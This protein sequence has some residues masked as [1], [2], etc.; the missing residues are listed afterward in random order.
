MKIIS[1]ITLLVIPLAISLYFMVPKAYYK[2]TPTQ[3]QVR[4]AILTPTTHPALQEIEQGFK[5]T[6]Q[7]LSSKPYTFTTFNANGNK[8]LLRAQAEEIILGN[9]QLIFT[10]GAGC[11]QTIAELLRKKG[12]HTPHLFGAIDSHAFAAS[13]RDMN[14]SSTGVYVVVD[15]KPT[16]DILHELKPTTKNILLVYDPTHGTGLEKYKKELADYVKKFGMTLHSSEIYQTN[17]IQ[18]KVAALLP[19]MDAVLVLIDNSVV[20]GIDALVTLCNRYGV[21]LVASD[22]ASGKKG[23]ALARGITEYE[24]G[25]GA[26]YK[27]YEILDKGKLSRD[28]P[29]D[30]ITNFKIEINPHTMQQQKLEPKKMA[31][32]GKC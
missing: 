25:S 29:L 28:L 8:T 30:A 27:A 16:I 10:I 3:K 15:Y 11:S 22:L 13:L 24:S 5:E 12:V 6:L 2:Q 21:T 32:R 14:A 4:I 9:Y 1:I 18:Q 26:A 31:G 17:E 19:S 23:A 7:K 20:A